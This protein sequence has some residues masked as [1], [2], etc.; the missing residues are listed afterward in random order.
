[1]STYTLIKV[2]K[3]GTS[4]QSFSTSN[5]YLNEYSSLFLEYDYSIASILPDEHHSINVVVS[6][7][8]NNNLTLVNP[9][10]MRLSINELEDWIK[11]QEHLHKLRSL[12]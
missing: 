6:I 10:I 1:M 2:S 11:N 3:Y 12:K 4:Q 7:E 8:L 9:E 5:E